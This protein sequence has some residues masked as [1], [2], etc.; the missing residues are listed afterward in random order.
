MPPD[1]LQGLAKVL[2]LNGIQLLRWY[3]LR[4]EMRKIG[5][6]LVVRAADESTRVN[7]YTWTKSEMPMILRHCD[8]RFFTTMR[9]K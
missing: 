6:L 5:L 1:K 4:L 3:E 2:R 9:C 8:S 7:S